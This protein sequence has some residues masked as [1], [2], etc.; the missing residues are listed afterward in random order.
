M[1]AKLSEE[2]NEWGVQISIK[3]KYMGFRAKFEDLQLDDNR[4]TEK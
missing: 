3:T 4:I 1:A 2:Y